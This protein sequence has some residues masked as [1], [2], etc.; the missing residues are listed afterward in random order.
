MSRAAGSGAGSGRP[1]RS[2]VVGLIARH[3]H[4]R[5]RDLRSATARPTR[6]R[7]PARSAKVT[8]RA[9]VRASTVGNS[10]SGGASSASQLTSKVPS[11]S[12]TRA[13]GLR[14]PS[15]W[16]GQR[17]PRPRRDLAAPRVPRTIPWPPDTLRPGS[18][19]VSAWPTAATTR[20]ARIM[21]C[22]AGVGPAWK[23]QLRHHR[24][25]GALLARIASQ[26]NL[27]DAW[28]VVRD[29][30]YADGVAGPEVE[31]FEAMAA[32]RISEV[33]AELAA[34]TWVPHPAHHVKIAKPKGGYPQPRHPNGRGPHRRTGRPGRGGS[35]GRS[36][37]HAVELRLPA[38]PRRGRCDPRAGRGS[39]LRLQLD[40][41]RRHRR[42]LRRDPSM[43]GDPAARGPVFRRGCCGTR[44]Q[45]RAP[46]CVRQQKAS[47]PR[48]RGL[49]Q[50]SPCRRCWPTSTW[51]AS[52]GPWPSAA[53][54]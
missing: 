38:R 12:Q 1:R 6:E 24:P 30:A 35:A 17:D 26:Q 19:P 39:G 10:G 25:M 40:G 34:G 28:E 52:T 8:L 48:S 41:A 27:L 50:G 44:A 18:S 33:A 54:R 9:L 36:P 29:S 37:A 53:D 2:N 46:A 51:T 20:H 21:H 15:S 45:A 23:P 31:K 43:A 14:D 42:L 22:P 3:R 32:R 5:R 47:K 16:P 11:T 49:H 4:D 7:L 13:R